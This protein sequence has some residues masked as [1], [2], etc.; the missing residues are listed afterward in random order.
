MAGRH[1]YLVGGDHIDS[2]SIF[3]RLILVSS[4]RISAVSSWNHQPIIRK[5]L[6]GPFGCA[7]RDDVVYELA[8]HVNRRKQLLGCAVECFSREYVVNCPKVYILILAAEVIH[9]NLKPFAPA[10]AATASDH[11]F[12][13]CVVHESIIS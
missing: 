6:G 3:S 7:F 9:W 10:I 4:D 12:V 1:C 5:G 11:L 8:A 13:Y 2:P